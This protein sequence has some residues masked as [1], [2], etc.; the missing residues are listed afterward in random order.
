M[1]ALY[2]RPDHR[3]WHYRS[4]FLVRAL[5]ADGHLCLDRPW[6][7][8]HKAGCPVAWVS[9]R[10][11]LASPTLLDDVVRALADLWATR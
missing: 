8:M 10:Y 4:P 6:I 9:M 3:P 11:E 2:L 5:I 1:D 7:G